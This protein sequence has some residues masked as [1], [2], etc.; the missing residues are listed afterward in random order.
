[1]SEE[2]NHEWSINEVNCI[3]PPYKS[4]YC[5]HCGL[6]EVAQNG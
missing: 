4:K 5:I 2:C 3:P 1:M 6:F